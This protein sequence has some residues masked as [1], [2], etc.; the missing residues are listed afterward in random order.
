[1]YQIL[2]IFT[3]F[4]RKEKT[5][6]CLEQLIQG[7]PDIRFRFI[8]VDDNSTDGTL[9]MLSKYEEVQVLRGNGNLYYSGGMRRGIAAA[10]EICDG[11]DKVMLLNDDVEFYP[12]AIEKLIQYSDEE[13]EIVAG[14]TCDKRGMLSYGGAIKKSKLRPAYQ[15]VMS[16]KGKVYCDTFNANCVLIPV[17]V[18]KILPNIDEVYTHYAGDYDYGLEAGRLGYSMTVSDFFVGE[19]EDNPVDGT[20]RD[21]KLSRKERLKRKESP[22]GLPRKEWYYFVKKNYGMPVACVS[23]VI[24]Y[25]KILIRRP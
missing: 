10:K 20:W 11:F 21:I 4:N 18:F 22:K 25:I 6:K 12:N 17:N 23:S 9:E 19:C 24:P 7:N 15:I 5:K 16:E 14:A 1:M 3:C 2:A 13:E 8:A